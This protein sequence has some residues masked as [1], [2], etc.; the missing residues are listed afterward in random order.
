MQSKPRPGTMDRYRVQGQ[1][2]VVTGSAHGIGLACAGLL[3]EA[4]ARVVIVDRDGPAARAAAQALGDGDARELDVQDAGGIGPVF[5]SIRAHH[6]PIGILINNAGISIRK[7]A[8]ELE[9]EMW[10]Q[11]LD[12]NVTGA[13]LCA[14]EA[15]RNMGAAGGCIVNTASIMGLSGGSLYPN[16]AYHTAKGAVVNMTRSLAIEWAPRRIRVNAVAP[17]WTRTSFI[18]EL[19]ADVRTRID[20]LTP[21]GRLAEPEDV[22]EA[23]LFLASP[24]ASMITGHI[25]P[26]DG[27]YLAQ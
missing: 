21:L 2:A 10:R 9:L 17:T 4:G 25:L 16:A 22:A 8:L 19:S 26:V 27:G 11:V 15:V 13:F 24:A 5:A 20:A 12:V 6:G 1:L 18:G 14:R 23:M 7:G 3:R